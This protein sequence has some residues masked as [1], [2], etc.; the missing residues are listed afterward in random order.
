MREVQTERP[1]CTPER[2]FAT[3]ILADRIAKTGHLVYLVLAESHAAAQALCKEVAHALKATGISD[4]MVLRQTGGQ[5]VLQGNITVLFRSGPSC[6]LYGLSVDGCWVA[7][8][9]PV[10][11]RE[12][13]NGFLAL[14]GGWAMPEVRRPPC[15]RYEPLEPEVSK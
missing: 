10:E 14:R 1:T 15:L 7:G 13:V 3:R 9:T 6:T 8:K 5:L 12:F 2:E 11:Y 4:M